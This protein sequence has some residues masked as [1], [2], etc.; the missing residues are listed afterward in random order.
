MQNNHTDKFGYIFFNLLIERG[1][2]G[3]MLEVETNMTGILKESS[4]N[5]VEILLG[6][7]LQDKV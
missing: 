6:T 1:A 2:V 5:F 4:A 3:N 7:P